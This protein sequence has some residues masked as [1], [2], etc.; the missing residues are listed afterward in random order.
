M[1]LEHH[2]QPVISKAA[3]RKRLSL[4][5]FFTLLSFTLSLAVGMVGYHLLEHLSWMDAFLNAAMLLGGMGPV[6]PPHSAG[7]KLFAGI[8]AIYSG[9]FLMVCGGLFLV[10]VFHRVLHRFHESS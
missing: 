9:I 7:G 10:P 4:W 6:D 8:Y 2:N 1:K 5:L 3:F